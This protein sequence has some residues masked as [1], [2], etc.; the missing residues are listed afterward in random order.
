MPL[1]MSIV[2]P[3]GS[4]W[5]TWSMSRTMM[6]IAV[7]SPWFMLVVS[8]ATSPARI[9]L[10]IAPIVDAMMMSVR[11]IVIIISM[12]VKP[13]SPEPRTGVVGE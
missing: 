4:P 8:V 5:P 3:E 13:A 11:P 7:R 6:S 1:G 10:F 12:S 9:A 2:R